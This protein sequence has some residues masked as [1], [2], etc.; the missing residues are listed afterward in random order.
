VAIVRTDVSEMKSP[1]LLEST[2]ALIILGILLY[3]EPLHRYEVP[4]SIFAHKSRLY[5]PTSTVS[6]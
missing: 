6:H 2:V 3:K 1:P 4:R 5:V